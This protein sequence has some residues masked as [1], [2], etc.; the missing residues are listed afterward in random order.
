LV[1]ARSGRAEVVLLDKSSYPRVKVCGSGLSP[2]AL[3]V[4]DR[5]GLRATLEPHHVPMRGVT[6]KG[7]GGMTVRLRGAKGAW[8]VPRRELDHAIVSAARTAGAGFLEDTKVTALL[9]DAAGQV[10]GVRTED[11]ELEA[12]AVVCANGSPSRFEVDEAPRAGIR[13][14]MGWWTG[15]RL[16]APDEGVM[17][18]DERLDGYYAWAFPEPNGVVNIGLTIPEASAPA[19]RIKPLFAELLDEHFREALRG[20][21]PIGKQMGHPATVTTRVGP[22]IEPRAVWCGEAARLVSPGSVE[23]IGFAM[24]SG[25]VAAEQLRALDPGTG[26]TSLQQARY[27]ARTA[28]RMLP[29]FW[30]GEAFTRLMRSSTAR[31]LATRLASPRWLSERAAALVGE[32]QR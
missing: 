14:L 10:R 1:L 21:E 19:G 5:L 23:G 7:P 9:R 17:I 3:G 8:V 28:V 25:M 4:I 20:A 31:R 24:E 30:A 22:I 16:P 15:V 12:D 32:R 18:W 26:L 6:V 29:K 2:H 27:R 11:G 13:T